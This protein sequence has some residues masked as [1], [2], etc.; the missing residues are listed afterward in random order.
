[1]LTRLGRRPLLNK[2]IATTA[3]RTKSGMAACSRQ[4]L[5]HLGALNQS[6]LFATIKKFTETHE[7]IEYDTE[8]LEGKIGITDHAQSE[9]GEVV[10][11]ELPEA[12]AEFSK[13]E[14]VA[15]VESTKTAADIYQMVDGE[16]ISVNEELA[17]D[18]GLVNSGAE[19]DG[20]M[21]E[22]KLT[23][24]GQTDNLMS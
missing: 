20:W 16:V 12:G 9:L 15:A 7:W 4:S 5:V 3:V 18:P 2:L 23:D 8:T 1:M 11:V 22:I 19:S 10:Y 6:R 24:A 14:V 13:S 21:I 17:N